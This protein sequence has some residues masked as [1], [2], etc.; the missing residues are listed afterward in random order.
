MSIIHIQDLVK[1]FRILKRDPKRFGALRSLFKPEYTTKR[2]IDGISLD[3]EEG[4]VVGYVGSNGAG[5]STTIK[6]L[7]GIAL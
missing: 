4:E 1:E 7:A 5:K 2:A 3:I 6:M